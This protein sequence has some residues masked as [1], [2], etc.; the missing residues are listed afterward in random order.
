VH[1]LTWALAGAAALA[2]ACSSGAVSPSS[3]ECGTYCHTI[4]LLH[5]PGTGET[6]D[7]CN[8]SCL[9]SWASYPKCAPFL[10]AYLACF[11]GKAETCDSVTCTSQFETANACTGGTTS[12]YNNVDGG[13]VPCDAGR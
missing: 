7:Q 2:A 10:D 1:A 8:T 4:A 12:C 13:A 5:C 6:E 11:N 3:Q 9:A